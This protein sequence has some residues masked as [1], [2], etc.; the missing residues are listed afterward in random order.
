MFLIKMISLIHKFNEFILLYIKNN[1]CVTI[2]IDKSKI[3]L[4]TS[5]GNVVKLLYI[6][7]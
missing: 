5:L 2:V 7:L 1:I 6:F 3:L 4:I